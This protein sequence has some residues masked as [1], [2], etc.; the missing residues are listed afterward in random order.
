MSPIFQIKKFSEIIHLLPNNSLGVQRWE[1]D[2]ESCKNEMVAFAEENISLENLTLDFLDLNIEVDNN[3][4]LDQIDMILIKGNIKVKNISNSETD[5]AVSLIV[6]GNL[7]ADNIVVGGQEIYVTGNLTVQDLFWGDYNHGQL[8]VD[9]FISAKVFMASD[10]HFNYERFYNNDNVQVGLLLN[11]HDVIGDYSRE[12]MQTAFLEECLLQE[13]EVE[14]DIYSYKNWINTA[15]LFNRL[16][17]NLPV[18]LGEI[19]VHP[20]DTIPFIFEDEYLTD[21]N[22]DRFRTSR[23]FSLFGGPNSNLKELEFRNESTYIRVRA[24]PNKPFSTNIYLTYKEEYAVMIFYFSHEENIKRAIAHQSLI[25]EDKDWHILD[26]KHSSKIVKDFI[27]AGWK[28]LLQAFSAAEYYQQQFSE[29]VTVQEINQILAL[30]IVK[31]KYSDYYNEDEHSLYVGNIMIQF[32]QQDNKAHGCP[33]ICI[34]KTLPFNHEAEKYVFY[35]LDILQ[36]ES[37]QDT[38]QLRTQ[39]EDGYES[40]VYAVSITNTNMYKEAIKYFT[41]L[42]KKILKENQEFINGF[43]SKDERYEIFNGDTMDTVTTKITDPKTFDP[44]AVDILTINEQYIQLKSLWEN[45]IYTTEQIVPKKNKYFN[46]MSG[47]LNDDIQCCSLEDDIKIPQEL[48]CFYSIHN[49]KYDPV[50][51]VFSFTV[52]DCIYYLLSFHEIPNEWNE[53]MDLQEID[54]RE[55]DIPVKIDDKLNLSNYTNPHW[56]PFASSR[57]GDYLLYDTDPSDKG[58]YGQIVELQNESWERNVVADSLEDLIQ[59]EIDMIKSGHVQ[60]FEFILR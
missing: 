3:A 26:F 46:L 12:L 53:V 47:I 36:N 20:G 22:L 24:Q 45:W 59:H 7:D 16:E 60:K 58:K 29:Q 51:S 10:Y 37:G 2:Q 40:T 4:V 27:E 11:D 48:I 44:G 42:K 33:R 28:Y 39:D 54:E 19:K 14:E 41:Q 15:K 23:L 6:L 31:S 30:P 8:N 5:G 49:V 17:E 55:N 18:L 21:I 43:I 25:G 9:G 32:R 50:T 52:N 34:I 56:I 57:D 13:D 1:Y 38:V 35:H